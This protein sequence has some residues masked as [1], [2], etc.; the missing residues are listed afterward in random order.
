MSE[1]TITVKLAALHVSLTSNP[2]VSIVPPNLH[3]FQGVD[4]RKAARDLIHT[5]IPVEQ[6]CERP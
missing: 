6:T 3:G 4:R 5:L 1:S 2:I